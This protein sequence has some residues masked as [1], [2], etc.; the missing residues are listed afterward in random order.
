MKKNKI[1]IIIAVV[2]VIIGG[3]VGWGLLQAKKLKTDVVQVVEKPPVVLFLSGVISS[4]DAVNNF[5]MV[6]PDNETK[7]IKVIVSEGTKIKK[8]EAPFD[9]NNPPE[10]GGTF[11]PK[12]TEIGISEVK[13]GDRIFIRSNEDIYGKEEINNIDFIQISS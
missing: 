5:L 13:E 7:E 8:L 9:L 3:L 11:S 10:G 4:I 12:E 1:I 2:V 6:K